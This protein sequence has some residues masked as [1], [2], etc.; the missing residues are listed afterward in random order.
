LRASILL[1]LLGFLVLSACAQSAPSPAGK[2]LPPPDGEIYH[3]AYPDFG[4]WEDE[5]SA[6]K[7]ADFEALTGKQIVWAYF[8]NNWWQPEPGI[9]FPVEH[10]RAIHE[11]GRVPFIRMMPRTEDPETGDMRLPDPHY[12]MQAIIDGEWDADLIQWAQAA[13]DTGIPLLV[14]FGTECNGNWFPWNAEWNGAESKTEYGDPGLYDGMERFRDAYRHII[15]LFNAQGVENITWFFHVDAYNDPAVPWNVMAGYYPGDEYI[16][17]IGVS[18]Y[19]PQES[20]EGW[21]L[22]SDVL[23]DSWEEIT[24]ISPGGKPIA[25]LEWGVIDYA[26]VGPKDVWIVDAF[27]TLLSGDYPEIKAISYWHENFDQTNLRLDSS[28][29]AIAAYRK[30]VASPA[31]VV[32]PLFSR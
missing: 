10:V 28:P 26:S 23:N 8:S 9:R 7:I 2:L 30:G 3:A 20:G 5:V 12:S 17:W 16:D 15:D 18:V 29:E 1:L 11:A 14:E 21:W 25:I 6:A 4:G 19:G 24:A 13:K 27:E 32:D 31:F 22:F